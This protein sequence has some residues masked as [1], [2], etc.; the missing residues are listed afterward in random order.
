M[1]VMNVNWSPPVRMLRQFCALLVIFAGLFTGITYV[2]TGNAA[3]AGTI[4]GVAAAIAAVGYAVPPVAR[5]VY[6]GMMFVT[7]P[8]GWVVSHL[9]LG[10]IFYLVFTPV[11]LMMK[12]AGYDPMKRHIDKSAKTYW[13]SRTPPVSTKRYF[14]QY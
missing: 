14:Q 5:V 10:G 4:F 12:A 13:Q 11:A 2:N 9:L 6:V 7:F 1:A 3:L 8:I